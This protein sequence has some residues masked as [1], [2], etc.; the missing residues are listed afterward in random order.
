MSESL[1]ETHIYCLG[2]RPGFSTLTPFFHWLLRMIQPF[3]FVLTGNN[4]RV[5]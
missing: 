4:S 5:N 1:V 3:F 2:M